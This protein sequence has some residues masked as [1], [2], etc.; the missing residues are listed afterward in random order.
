MLADAIYLL[1]YIRLYF[2]I[3]HIPNF[4]AYWWFWRSD[5]KV[6]KY[7]FAYLVSNLS[8][9]MWYLKMRRIFPSSKIFLRIYDEFIS[10]LTSRLLFC[11]LFCNRLFFIIQKRKKNSQ[12]IIEFFLVIYENLIAEIVFFQ[13]SMIFAISNVLIGGNIIKNKLLENADS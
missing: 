1:N 9:I 12:Q 10:D 6:K 4:T 5:L 2:K 3:S 7:I 13:Q 11:F 8:S